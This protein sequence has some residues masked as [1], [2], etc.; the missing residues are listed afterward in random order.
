MVAG[1]RIRVSDH[2]HD[3]GGDSG[4]E[5]HSV[6]VWDPA[7]RRIVLYWFDPA[8]GP[9]REYVG[10]YEGETLVLE[11]DGPQGSR[12]RHRTDLPDP[13][14]LRTR[15]SLS[16]DGDHW[17]DLAAVVYRR[18]P[19]VRAGPQPDG[20]H[21]D[22]SL[23]MPDTAPSNRDAPPPGPDASLPSPDPDAPA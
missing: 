1:D 6:T 4:L 14:T 5:G 8:G 9:P 7:R 10:D 21:S 11:G 20:R 23:P 3:L 19:D 15:S 16:F 13:D 12:I 22:A 17:Q 2:R 18:V